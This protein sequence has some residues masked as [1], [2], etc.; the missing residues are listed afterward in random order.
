MQYLLRHNTG[1]M[2]K[3]YYLQMAITLGVVNRIPSA[4]LRLVLKYFPAL[5]LDFT[6][7]IISDLPIIRPKDVN[8]F[9]DEA[10]LERI[11]GWMKFK[12]GLTISK[13]HP[14]FSKCGKF[15]RYRLKQ[16]HHRLLEC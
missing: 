9:P 14:V 6:I 5:V 3:G 4:H 15:I 1:L 11:A 8:Y 13:Y 12:I 7:S 16:K 10:D 2:N